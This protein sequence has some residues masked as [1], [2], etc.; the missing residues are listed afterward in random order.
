MQTRVVSMAVER[1][2]PTLCDRP[3]DALF[4]AVDLKVVSASR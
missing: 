4:R 1:E 3:E 2:P